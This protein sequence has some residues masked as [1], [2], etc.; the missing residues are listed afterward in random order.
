LN[1][2]RA[3]NDEDEE[4]ESIASNHRGLISID[5][6]GVALERNCQIVAYQVE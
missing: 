1:V 6:I 5:S 4:I 3:S 2:V